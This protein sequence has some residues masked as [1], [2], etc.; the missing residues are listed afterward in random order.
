MA[1]NSGFT[2]IKHDYSIDPYWESIKTSIDVKLSYSLGPKRRK[3][4]ED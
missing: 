2:H 3:Y 1:I 4:L